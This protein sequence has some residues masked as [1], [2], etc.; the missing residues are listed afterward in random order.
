ME[1]PLSY[2]KE[3]EDTDKDKDKDKDKEDKEKN[4]EAIIVLT[5]QHA[6][7]IC[8]ISAVTM[9]TRHVLPKVT[10]QTATSPNLNFG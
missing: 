8:Y 4:E 3:E 7:R 5:L 9:Q 2:D 10:G 1:P 6:H